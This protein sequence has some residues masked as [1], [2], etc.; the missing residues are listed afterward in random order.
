MK[1]LI[2]KL[3]TLWQR[4]ELASEQPQID[5]E[6]A[7]AALMIEIINADQHWEA[8]E[9]ALVKKYLSAQMSA[10]DVEAMFEQAVVDSREALDL[11]QFTSLIRDQY[12]KE[13]KRDLLVQL[14]RIAYADGNLDKYEDYV[15]RKIADLIYIPQPEFIRAKQIGRLNQ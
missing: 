7:A 12:S 5:V 9:K 3:T 11:H 1:N 14:W 13:Q 8:S 10:D 2:D 6:R 4:E 15:I